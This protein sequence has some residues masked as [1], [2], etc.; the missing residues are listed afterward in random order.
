MKNFSKWIFPVVTLIIILFA[1]YLTMWCN[2]DSNTIL[3][4]PYWDIHVGNLRSNNPIIRKLRK[5]LLK[6]NSNLL[7]IPIKPSNKSYTY[8]KKEIFLCCYDKNGKVYDEN[9]LMYALLHEVAHILTDFGAD[10]G[11]PHGNEFKEIFNKLLKCA[12]QKGIWNP[13]IPIAKS[14]KDVCGIKNN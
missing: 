10:H 2:G 3:V 1:Y 11:D 12:I 5:N 6:I 8:S 7:K 14:Y 13:Y 9:T 4:E